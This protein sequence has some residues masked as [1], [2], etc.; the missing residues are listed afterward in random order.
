MNVEV[1]RAGRIKPSLKI[2][3]ECRSLTGPG[4]VQRGSLAWSSK[5]QHIFKGGGGADVSRCNVLFRGGWGVDVL[6]WWRCNIVFR[7]GFQGYCLS[8]S[9]GFSACP[10]ASRL[11]GFSRLLG[12]PG[13]SSASRLLGFS[14]C[15]V[16]S[17]LLGFSACAG[18]LG[19]SACVVLRGFSASRLVSGFSASR[20]LVAFLGPFCP[21]F[22]IYGDFQE[23]IDWIWYLN[24]YDLELPTSPS[25]LHH[26]GLNWAWQFQVIQ[27]RQWHNFETTIQQW[28][29][30]LLTMLASGCRWSYKYYAQ[31]EVSFETHV[32]DRTFNHPCVA[33]FFQAPIVKHILLDWVKSVCRK[34]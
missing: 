18:L 25:S 27:T 12:L 1:W 19:F 13:G 3:N 24:L 23:M 26:K 29:V 16:A 9:G 14:A 32:M 7:G 28:L 30:L 10:A 15:P 17:R 22:V 5:L 33:I 34:N 6:W 8:L 4:S 2:F 21:C 20:L 11:R 31:Q